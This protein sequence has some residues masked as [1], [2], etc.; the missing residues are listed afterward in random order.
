M[1]TP[2]H[3]QDHRCYICG[4]EAH[5]DTTAQGGHKFWRNDD[6]VHLS[7]RTTTDYDVAAR[8]VDEWIG[9]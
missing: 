2:I 8:Y 9:R 4:G 7:L 6:A 5:A 3:L 1:P